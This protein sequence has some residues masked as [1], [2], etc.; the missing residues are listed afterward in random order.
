MHA[1]WYSFGFLNEP[2]TE[3][4]EAVG[5]QF[6][7]S[8]SQA[9]N[10]HVDATQSPRWTEEEVWHCRWSKGCWVDLDPPAQQYVSCPSSAGFA[11][12]SAH[13]GCPDAAA[14]SYIFFKLHA[15][16]VFQMPFWVPPKEAILSKKVFYLHSQT[17]CYLW[18]G[19][20]GSGEQRKQE[21]GGVA[22]DLL[23]LMSCIPD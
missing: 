8:T 6:D 3:I 17:C 15:K 7:L 18:G 9:C 21:W 2:R 12:C 23:G 11:P 22:G 5:I 16:N 20:R 10:K 4:R 14:F 13:Q 19:G 1:T